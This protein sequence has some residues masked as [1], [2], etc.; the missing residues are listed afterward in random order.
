M[1]SS[2]RP[3][4]SAMNSELDM[5]RM[6][7]HGRLYILCMMSRERMYEGESLLAYVNSPGFSVPVAF[8]LRFYSSSTQTH[9]PFLPFSQISHPSATSLSISSFF[10]YLARASRLAVVDTPISLLV[11]DIQAVENDLTYSSLCLSFSQFTW[12]SDVYDIILAGGPK[13]RSGCLSNCLTFSL[14]L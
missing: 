8:G 3:Y 14:S 12:S 4:I 11:S 2:H 9:F 6:G 13:G 10:R 1:V 7:V 5:N